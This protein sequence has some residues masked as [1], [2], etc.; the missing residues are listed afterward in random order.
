MKLLEKREN[1]IKSILSRFD[2]RQVCL[3]CSEDDPEE[4]Y[5]RLIGEFI[6]ERF[7][8]NLEIIHLGGKNAKLQRHN[9]NRGTK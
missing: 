6:K 2:I 3:L 8:K 1:E 4:C 7:I 9:I 5:G